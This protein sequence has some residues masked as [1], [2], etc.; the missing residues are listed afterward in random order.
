MDVF[1]KELGQLMVAANHLNIE[2]D[3]KDSS[4][5]PHCKK[6]YLKVLSRG[7]EHE[8]YLNNLKNENEFLDIVFDCVVE[9]IKTALKVAIK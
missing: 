3:V 4:Y 9:S 8:I 1:T 5:S 2:I 7:F 6:V